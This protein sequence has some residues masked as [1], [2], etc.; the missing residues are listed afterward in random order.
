MIWV[1]T[2]DRK[3]KNFIGNYLASNDETKDMSK[4]Y[5]EYISY[6]DKERIE[7][8]DVIYGSLHMGEV[9][10]INADIEYFNVIVP[11]RERKE[12]L[13]WHYRM[14]R[15]QEGTD[16]PIIATIALLGKEECEEIV[17]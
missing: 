17:I 3:V 15:R 14:I 9:F 1:I 4:T 10:S 6:D 2:K 7:D 16:T 13:L 8:G 5:C 11:K 12:W